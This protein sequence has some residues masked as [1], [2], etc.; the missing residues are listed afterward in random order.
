MGVFFARWRASVA[1]FNTTNTKEQSEYSQAHSADA[2]QPSG[3]L[4]N[5]QGTPMSGRRHLYS[6]TLQNHP[7]TSLHTR[8]KMKMTPPP[9]IR[10]L[11]N[12]R[13]QLTCIYTIL[14]VFSILLVY[15]LSQQGL[16]SGALFF[17]TLLLVVLGSIITFVLTSFL[18][19]PLRHITDAAQA[20]ATGDTRQQERLFSRNPP[21]DE[22]DRLAGSLVEM[23][24][25][26][27]RADAL[28]QA[29]EQRFRRFF[30]DAS[31]QL[32]TPLTSLRGFTE[33]L[34][35]GLKDDPEAMQRA[36]QLMKGE[37]ERMT[38]LINDLLTLARLDDTHPLRLRYCD[39][40]KL[41]RERIDQIKTQISD[42]R[43]ITLEVLNEQDMGLQADEER[44]KQLLYVLLDNA[45]KYG[46]P[47]PEGVITLQLDR[48][49]E[50]IIIRV[51]D[52]GEGIAPEDLEHI[53]DS[54]YRGRP[55]RTPSDTIVA[56]T[57]LGLTIAA[58][59]VR[60]HKGSID[61]ESTPQQGTIFTITLPCRQ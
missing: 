5:V 53:F 23:A 11:G 19:T 18:L 39:L 46:R 27:E 44:L 6:S 8:K 48:R 61:V 28:Q 52:N 7:P 26:I 17:I 40:K 2:D 14:L 16:D 3:L 56:G 32:R 58:T 25:R 35:R 34:L 31:H 15:G 33:V 50:I 60:I 55:H 24:K 47:A 41:A 20:I 30:S 21:Q 37:T 4:K 42:E 38:L 45:V 13:V 29:S 43:S 51:I 9:W 10:P 22:Y 36:L 1:H 49:D 59:I 57:G 54:F 12:L